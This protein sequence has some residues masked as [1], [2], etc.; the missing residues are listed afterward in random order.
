M[1][2]DSKSALAVPVAPGLPRLRNHRDSDIDLKLQL[3]SELSTL[4]TQQEWVKAHQD[5][6]PWHTIQYHRDLKLSQDTTY[7]SW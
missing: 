6:Q 3:Q 5:Q 1:V 4:T 7:N 2:C